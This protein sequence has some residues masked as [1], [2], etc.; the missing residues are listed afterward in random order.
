MCIRDSHD[1]VGNHHNTVDDYFHDTDDYHTADHYTLD[2][3]TVDCHNIVDFHNILVHYIDYVD[4]TLDHK[5]HHQQ[6]SVALVEPEI[7]YL[8]HYVDFYEDIQMD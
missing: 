4:D 7:F 2:D 8:E 5:K 3:H 6:Y 1:T